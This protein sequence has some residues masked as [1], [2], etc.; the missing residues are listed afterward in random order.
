MILRRMMRMQVTIHDPLETALEYWIKYSTIYQN[1]DESKE[2]IR[3][4]RLEIKHLLDKK[5]V[6]EVEIYGIEGS[7][8]TLRYKYR[9]N[10]IFTTLE[11]Q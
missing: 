10:K 7:A 8:Y 6:T 9:G 1:N 5:G 3:R 2:E 4:K 11:V